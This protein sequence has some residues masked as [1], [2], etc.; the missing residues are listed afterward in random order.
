L[1]PCHKMSEEASNEKQTNKQSWRS[2]LAAWAAK[3][4]VSDQ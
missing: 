2:D 1:L 4:W 3:G